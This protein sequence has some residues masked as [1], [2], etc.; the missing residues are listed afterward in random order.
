M[1]V[2]KNII[3]DALKH[4]PNLA[5]G[6]WLDYDDDND[7]VLSALK[8]CPRCAVGAVL[9]AVLPPSTE[10]SELDRIAMRNVREC[11]YTRGGHEQ[12]AKEKAEA[13]LYFDALSIFFE[14]VFF[15]AEQDGD[16]ERLYPEKDP[17]VVE[18]AR[19]RTIK[20][21]EAHFPD[22]IEL[23]LAPMRIVI[24]YLGA[25]PQPK[26]P[27]GYASVAAIMERFYLP[28]PEVTYLQSANRVVAVWRTDKATALVQYLKLYDIPHHV[29]E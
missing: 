29:T 13:G 22:E 12:Y 3:I 9:T 11:V 5:P 1:K 24:A 18:R 14:G 20:F 16:F 26:S 8:D 10:A 7:D 15:E 4:E 23:N 6:M 28:H 21:V 27:Y 25:E 19:T 2:T 17:D